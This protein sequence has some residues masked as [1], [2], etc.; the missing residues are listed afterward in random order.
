MAVDKLVDS[1]QLDSDL[2]S[3]ANAIRT[4][5]GTSATMSFPSGFVSAIENI[6]TGGN[7]QANKNATPGASQQVVT[8]DTGYDGMEQVTVSGDANLV[9]EN[10]KKDVEIFGV[11]GSYEGGGG[12]GATVEALSVTANGTY[13][14][15]TG[16]AYSPVTVNVPNPVSIIDTV[17]ENGGTVR[18]IS[19][20]RGGVSFLDYDGTVV[21]FK[22]KAEINAM[23]SDSD[24]PANPSHTGLVAQGWNRTVTQLKAQLTAMPEQQVY[25]G[26]MYVTQSGKT[27]IDVV[28]QEGR[29]S[30]IMTICVNGTVS[31]DWG[32]NTTPDTVTGTSESTRLE[33]GPHN[34]ASAG[35]YTIKISVTSGSFAF[36][37]TTSYTL[38]RKNTTQNENIVYANCV[39]KIRLGTG[40]SHLW[41]YAFYNCRSLTS[42]TIPS[43]VT[44]IE[45]NAFQ[46]CYSLT[47][48]TIPS[49]VTSIGSTVFQNCYSLTSVT[50]PSSVTSIGN[51]EFQNCYSLTS[52]TIP[53]SVTSIG[54]NA[55]YYCYSLTS[56]AIPSGVTSIGDNTFCNCYSLTNVTIPSGV[57]SIG[58]YAFGSCYSLTSVTIPS[59]VTSI[60]TYAFQYCYS[61]TCVTIPSS[62]TSIGANA[63]CYCHS[64]TSFTIPSRV[65]SIEASTFSSCYSLASV[66]IPSSVTSIGS[67][68]FSG[69]TSLKSVTIP[70][71]ITSIE[72]NAFYACYSLAS[73]TIPSDVTSI[74]ATAFYACYSLASITIPIDVTSIG[75]N[76]FLQ[77]YG[78]KEYHILPTTVPTAGTE[79]FKNIVSDCVIYVPQGTLTDYQTASNWSTYAS[80][81]QEEPT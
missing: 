74:G 35:D 58:S 23:S 27:E 55:F 54:N 38:L 9:A 33:V 1:N 37:G 31:I 10:I 13:T 75:N 2:T 76:A 56:V 79:I 43:S 67:S 69:C 77:C 80:Y 68:A 65:T 4:K 42:V 19:T 63:F 47:S 24:L 72:S 78:V 71:G 34:Y 45:A 11:T 22:T 50:F 52:V 39:K 6:P 51:N 14:A 46:N 44:S 62:V 61:L 3:V 5:G 41:N 64:L 48:V 36:Y 73:V 49:S 66:T 17:D 57:T 40:I 60:G 15:P 59:G 28:M 81:M 21:A 7:L 20:G 18:R 32:D 70:S 29:L 26:Q 30:P 12:G 8:P 16:K 53:S 25:V